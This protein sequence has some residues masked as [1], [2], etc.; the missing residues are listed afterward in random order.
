MLTD[1]DCARSDGIN[2]DELRN[3]HRVK[4]NK[5]LRLEKTKSYTKRNVKLTV[6]DTKIH[7]A[8]LSH[9]YLIITILSNVFIPKTNIQI[10]GGN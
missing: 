7:I 2:Y 4:T 3:T 8:V 9:I 6:D 10:Y 1:A 5:T